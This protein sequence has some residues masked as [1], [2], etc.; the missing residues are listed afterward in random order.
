M[1]YDTT[2]SDIWL[3][4]L[5]NDTEIGHIRF[6]VDVDPIYDIV[7]IP[8]ATQPKLLNTGSF[9]IR[10]IFQEHRHLLQL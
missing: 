2:Y 1:E 3:I 5:E 6:D 8:D 10:H 7:I 9:L 4:N